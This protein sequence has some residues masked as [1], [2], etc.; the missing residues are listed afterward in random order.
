MGHP[1]PQ[2]RRIHAPRHYGRRCSKV[3]HAGAGPRGNRRTAAA[4]GPHAFKR[5]WCGGGRGGCCRGWVWRM[6]MMQQLSS[7]GLRLHLQVRCAPR[8][9]ALCANTLNLLEP[10]LLTCGRVCCV[11]VRVL[12]Q[13]PRS[14]TCL[15]PPLRGFPLPALAGLFLLCQHTPLETCMC[16]MHTGQRTWAQRPV[17]PDQPSPPACATPLPGGRRCCC[18]TCRQP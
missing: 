15:L 10:A 7:K 3:A 14:W 11:R 8:T 9:A 5:G 13:L 1:R 17:A 12:W 6:C 16:C 18:C 2:Q 4:A